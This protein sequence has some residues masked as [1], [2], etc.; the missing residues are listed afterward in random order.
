[1]L[2]EIDGYEIIR[3]LREW[4]NVAILVVSAKGEIGDRVKCLKLGADDYLVKPFGIEELLARVSAIL[5]RINLIDNYNNNQQPI[6]SGLIRIDL[7]SR[8]VIVDEK[9][10]N[11]TPTEFILL[12]E[13][14]LN[15]NKIL[16]HEHLLAKIWGTEYINDRQYL[17][18]FVGKIRRKIERD[19]DMPTSSVETVSGIGYIYHPESINTIDT[20]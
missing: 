14:L 9:E 12:K 16:T 8:K 11:F 15:P 2:P 3:L 6:I 10:I 18:V 17:H 5:R 19:Q 7:V 4:T 13:F 1:M 20:G